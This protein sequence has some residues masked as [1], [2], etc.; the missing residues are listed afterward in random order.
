[1]NIS[2][3]NVTDVAYHYLG[4]RVLEQLGA[5]ATRD[6]QIGAI[7]RSVL[8][9][10]SDRALRLMLPEPKGTF[11]SVGKKICQELV[12][13]SL[14]QSLDGR[15]GLTPSGVDA[16][17]MLDGRSHEELRRLMVRL[18]LHTYDNLRSILDKHIETDGFW[19]PIVDGARLNQQGYAQSL[20]EPSLGPKAALVADLVLESGPML[21]AKR[22]EDRL[23]EAILRHLLPGV[24]VSEPLFRSMVDRLISLR[25][26]NARRINKGSADF[27]ISY[28]VCQKGNPPAEWYFPMS[29][30]LPSGDAYS[31]HLCE[32]DMGS[33]AVQ[34]T[35]LKTIE[36]AF[37]KL[38]PEAGYFDVP[39]VRDFVCASLRIPEAAFDEG[40]NRLLDTQPSPLTVGL[41]YEGIS[42]RRRPIVRR[43]GSTSHIFNLMRRT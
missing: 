4:L 8:K 7:S 20:L 3:Y 2:S 5:D 24:V 23:R 12:H 26:V 15:Y 10:V 1:M 18:H 14:A 37:R 11:E 36:E 19:R 6:D 43:Q 32:P 27:E 16:L 29:I 39:E 22:L 33:R 31:I 25:L 30:V 13:L 38:Q 35:L 9:Y 21:T 41:R 34:S 40:V 17:R 42:G 28:P